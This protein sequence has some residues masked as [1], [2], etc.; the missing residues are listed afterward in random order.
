MAR[1][2][3]VNKPDDYPG[4]PDDAT[5]RDLAALFDYLCPRMPNPE[6]DSAHAGIAIAAHIP[7]LALQL[8]KLGGL[9]AGELAWCQRRDLRELA[10]QSLNVH[11]KCDYSFRT[12]MS[13]ASAAGIGIELQNA[14]PF[15]KSSTLFDDEQRL[16]IEYT[17]AVVTGE[18]PGTLFSRV[19]DQYGEKGAIELTTV[20]AFWS[21]WARFLNATRPDAAT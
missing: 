16:V 14:L 1:V 18:V 10:I 17:H 6:I 4:S 5:R 3:L 12:R 9:I 19:V 15:W 13:T 2:T 7:K 8:A 20:V 21:F 11:F